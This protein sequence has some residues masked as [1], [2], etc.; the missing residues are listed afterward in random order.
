MLLPTRT[1]VLNYL[2]QENEADVNKIMEALRP[3]YG[4][5]K[6]FNEKMYLEHAMSLEANGLVEMIGYELDKNE[7]L[8]LYYRI[9]ESGRKAVEKY[10]PEKYYQKEK[11]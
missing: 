6:Q 9:N 7:E 8:I 10:V 1:A 3:M 5:E 2:Y 4:N 11:R